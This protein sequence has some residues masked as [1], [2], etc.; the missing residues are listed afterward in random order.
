M[1]PIQIS[2]GVILIVV[3]LGGI[4]GLTRTIPLATTTTTVK[5]I[6][7]CEIDD[8][9]IPAEP[10]VGV[11]YLCENNVCKTKPFGNPVSCQIDSDCVPATCCHPTT[12]VNKDY[13][14]DC[15]GMFCTMEC[16][17]NTM[18]CGQGKCVCADNTCQTEMI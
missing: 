13:R 5:T 1:N 14:P 12:C 4:W 17:P 9:C 3:L 7:E 8:D 11:R 10:L 18:D 16:A 15:K 2:I 6:T